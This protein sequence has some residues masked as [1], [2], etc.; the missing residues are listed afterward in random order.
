MYIAQMIAAGELMVIEVV[1]SPRGRPSSRI[2]MSA[3]EETQ[4]PHLP[5]SPA[6]WGAS[7]S[8]P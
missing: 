7:A 4:T 6:A 1:I 3:R 2:S 5:N 8:N